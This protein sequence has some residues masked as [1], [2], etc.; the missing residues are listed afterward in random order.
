M[1]KRTAQATAR[2][3]ERESRSDG[4]AITVTGFRVWRGRGGASYEINC[5]DHIEGGTFVVRS[6]ED[7][8]DRHAQ[9]V[10]AATF[11]R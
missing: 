3:I 2:R 10:Y 6:P 7:W 8:D 9:A 11:A 5:Q 4:G 1:D